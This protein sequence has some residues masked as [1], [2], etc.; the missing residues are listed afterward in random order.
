LRPDL[1]DL[2]ERLGIHVEADLTGGDL[3]EQVVVGGRGI[4]QGGRR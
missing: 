2:G 3:A 4:A 1:L